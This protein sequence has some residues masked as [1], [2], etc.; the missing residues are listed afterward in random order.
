MN[1]TLSPSLLSADF[2]RLG[3]EVL[4]LEKAG[5]KWLHLDV[6]DGAFVPNLTFGAPIIAALRPLCHLFFDTHLMIEN[7]ERLVDD[8]IGAGANLV[9]VHLE[10]A[11]NPRQLLEKIKNA[12]VKAGVSIN[13]GTEICGLRWLLPVLDMVM[14]MGVNPGFSGQKFIP[15]TIAKTREC[16]EF[17]DNLGYGATPIQVDGGVTEA[18]AAELVAAGASSLVSGSAF[19]GQKNYAEALKNFDRASAR[20]PS[21]SARALANIAA[22]PQT[23]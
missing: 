20:A 14:L 18:N 7:P 5:V 6:M 13:P 1:F 3:E 22:W 11:K 23:Y 19:F 15:Q 8:F 16:R 9:V 10:A 12:G 4:A 21:H 2:S 17:L